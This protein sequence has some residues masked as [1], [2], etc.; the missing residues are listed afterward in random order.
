MDLR[1]AV[2]SSLLVQ[3]PVLLVWLAGIILA[4]VYWKR[5]PT[6][7]LLA[8]IAFAVLMFITLIDTY[9]SMA[10]SLVY[11]R[12][13]A[14]TSAQQGVYFAIKSVAASILRAAA[15]TLLLPAIFG[16]RNQRKA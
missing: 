2:L 3:I 7:A 5:C 16:W 12:E 13:R 15:Y 9:L 6:A 14:W 4:L 1:Y 10:F 8:L 11:A